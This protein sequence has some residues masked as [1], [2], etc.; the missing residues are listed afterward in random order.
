MGNMSGA[1]S[2]MFSGAYEHTVDDKCRL[3]IPA[4]LRHRLG[5]K[6]VITR[7]LH[8]CLWIFS[9]DTWPNVQEALVPKSLWDERGLKLERFFLG[10]AMECVP[11]KQGRVPI[12]PM[13]SQHAGIK[14]GDTV[15]MIGLTGK[16]EVWEKSRWDQF[17]AELTDS[18]I[19]ELGRDA[20]EPR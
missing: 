12:P 17:S 16:I 18:V 13:L 9:Q 20:E 4:R 14:P 3:V 7:G 1:D 19:A 6:F 15:W 8:G 10:A 11:D 2:P 5:D